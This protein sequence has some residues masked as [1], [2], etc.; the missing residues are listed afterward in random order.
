MNSCFG[1]LVILFSQVSLISIYHNEEI[2]LIEAEIIGGFKTIGNF[3]CE[4]PVGLRHIDKARKSSSTV[5]VCSGGNER[6]GERTYGLENR[7]VA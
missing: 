6:T 2:C 7:A 1:T 5:N 4:S 3:E